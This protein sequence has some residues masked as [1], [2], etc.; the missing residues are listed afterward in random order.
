MSRFDPDAFVKVL[1][2]RSGVP[3][4]G[5]A[6]D[7]SVRVYL[8]DPGLHGEVWFSK[9]FIWTIRGSMWKSAREDFVKDLL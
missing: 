8:D 4:G 3:C 5:S 2:R 9:V 6:P 1:S 7:D